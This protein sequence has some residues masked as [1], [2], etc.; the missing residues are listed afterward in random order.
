MFV[1]NKLRAGN[2]KN[3]N[4]W[5]YIG[6]VK[7]CLAIKLWCTIKWCDHKIEMPKAVVYHSVQYIKYVPVCDCVCVAHK[8]TLAFGGK[9]R[10]FCPGGGSHHDH[11]HDLTLC[12]EGSSN[13]NLLVKL[14]SYT[15]R[16]SSFQQNAND[17]LTLWIN[18]VTNVSFWRYFSTKL[19]RVLHWPST[20]RMF[21]LVMRWIL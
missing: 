13:D 19:K 14:H 20:C 8:I 3:G 11:C 21:S 6:K 17:L 18:L 9:S 7:C 15:K 1:P 12:C 2:W 10:A 16:R 4:C 5:C